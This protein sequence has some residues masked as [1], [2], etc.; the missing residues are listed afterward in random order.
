[1]SCHR[2]AP[3]TRYL[4]YLLHFY[5]PPFEF[6]DPHL[7]IC[8]QHTLILYIKSKN[9]AGGRTFMMWILSCYKFR[10]KQGWYV[11]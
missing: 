2:I 3:L 11:M 10:Y 8:T 9:C 7:Q 6:P 4:Y 1:M 5:L